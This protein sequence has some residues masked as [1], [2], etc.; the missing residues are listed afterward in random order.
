MRTEGL[1]TQSQ[2]LTVGAAVAPEPSCSR[3][4]RSC[5]TKAA[6]AGRAERRGRA[7]ERRGRAGPW[8]AGR[9]G[10]RTGAHLASTSPS[11]WPTCRTSCARRSTPILI[12][13]QQLAENSA[14]NLH[15]PSRSSSRATST[16][17]APTCLHL[18]NDILDLSKIESGTQSTVEIEEITFAGL[19]ETI[20]RNFR[21]VAEAKSTAVPDPRSIRRPAAPDGQ[22]PQAAAADPEEPARPT[23]SSSPR[24]GHVQVRVAAR[25]QRLERR[26]PGAEHRPSTWSRSRWRTPASACRRTSS[27]LI[28]E[29]FQQADAGTSR[30]VRRHRPGPSVSAA[31]WRCCSAARSGHQRARPGQHVHAVPAAALCR[32][33]LSAHHRA[34]ARRFSAGRRAAGDDA[35]GGARGARPDDRDNDPG[36]RPGAA[37]RSRTTR[38]TPASCSGWRATSASRASSPPRARMALVAGAPVP[39]RRPSRSRHLP[40]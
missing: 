15:R 3:P 33:E 11:S 13:S 38:T 31:S 22:R 16:P 36:R 35:A 8:R 1:L 5:G 10:G 24:H 17:R 6:A 40:A 39:C 29:A 2:Q 34:C 32:P 30:E 4:T 7:Q 20:D 37:G 25:R 23:R 28:F 21:H 9:E 26:P 14:G 27:A 19:R 12:L 18:I